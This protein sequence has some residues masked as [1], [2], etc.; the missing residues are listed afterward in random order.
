MLEMQSVHARPR[1]ASAPLHAS[2]WEDSM[3]R[4]HPQRDALGLAKFGKFLV[5]F[6]AY[7]TTLFLLSLWG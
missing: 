4:F 7:L 2:D 6:W 5:F 3:N 1:P